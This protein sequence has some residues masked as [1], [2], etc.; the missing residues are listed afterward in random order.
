M[1]I[2]LVSAADYNTTYKINNP[3]ATVKGIAGQVFL[4]TYIIL[5]TNKTKTQTKP[6]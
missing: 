6:L 1:K 3:N 4:I 2:H 5:K